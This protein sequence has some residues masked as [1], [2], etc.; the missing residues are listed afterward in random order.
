MVPNANTVGSGTR[1][2]AA[3]DDVPDDDVLGDEPAVVVDISDPPRS[4]D[5]FGAP[6]LA[7]IR[8]WLQPARTPTDAARG[9]TT[10]RRRP[11]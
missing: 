2:E 1:D 10:R 9:V 5:A 3:D 4:S 8:S 7:R 11:R 6:D